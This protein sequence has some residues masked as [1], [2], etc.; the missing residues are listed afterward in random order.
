[1]HFFRVNLIIRL[2]HFEHLQNEW[3]PIASSVCSEFNSA[4]RKNKVKLKG[5]GFYTIE[6]TPE[7]HFVDGT[8]PYNPLGSSVWVYSK[9]I[10]IT[11]YESI[12]KTSIRRFVIEETYD[13]L[14]KLL[15]VRQLPND[16]FANTLK[17]INE[18]SII[19]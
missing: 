5:S 18:D 4:F 1:M 19:V 14:M 9:Y 15:T 17:T 6:F 11:Q 2:A 7:E 12:D 8:L 3:K 10:S 13:A 16:I